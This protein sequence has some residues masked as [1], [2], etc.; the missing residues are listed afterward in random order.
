V[1][2]IF[3][4]TPVWLV[5]YCWAMVSGYEVEL[6]CSKQPLGSWIRRASALVMLASGVG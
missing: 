2:I 1:A 5:K 3:G 6:V 4:S